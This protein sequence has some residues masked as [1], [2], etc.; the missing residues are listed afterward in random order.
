MVGLVALTALAAMAFVGAS[1]AVAKEPTALCHQNEDPC[2]ALSIDEKG[3]PHGRITELH[4]TLNGIGILHGLSPLFNVLCLSGLALGE[5][6]GL[7][8][9]L[10]VEGKKVI[11][12]QQVHLSKLDFTLCGTNATH[13]NCE[14]K[15]LELPILV[16]V[17]RTGASLGTA[18]GLNGSTLVKCNIPLIG[19]IDC[20]YKGEGLGFDVKSAEAAKKEGEKEIPANHGMLNAEAT[21]V[22][23]T[24]G[25]GFCSEESTI[26]QG[27]LEPLT[28]VYISS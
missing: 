16:D 1:S 12:P 24:A 11:D 23:K 25:S 8:G 15:A 28:D 6:L 5:V 18:T 14:I 4:M 20:I 17:L 13:T 19:T 3:V 26:T 2:P 9:E 21:P 10:V 7:G 22:E 27:L